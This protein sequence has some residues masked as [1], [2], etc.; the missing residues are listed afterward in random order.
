MLPVP[1]RLAMIERRRSRGVAKPVG[2]LAERHARH[3]AERAQTPQDARKPMHTDPSTIWVICYQRTYREVLASCGT[4][5]APSGLG[6]LPHGPPCFSSRSTRIWDSRVCV[7]AAFCGSDC[8]GAVRV[9][10]L[11]RIAIRTAGFALGNRAP[12]RL[13]PG[14]AWL[15]V[16]TMERTVATD[17]A[18]RAARQ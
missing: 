8:R 10:F 5:R 11:S 2:V 16:S 4:R 7:G 18:S 15:S 13:P 3:L 14:Y 1:D 12:G 9:G 6:L 17:S